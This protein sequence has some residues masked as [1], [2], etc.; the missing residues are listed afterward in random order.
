MD[1]YRRKRDELD[2]K[3]LRTHCGMLLKNQINESE[4]GMENVLR[5][6]VVF[7][8]SQFPIDA[9]L[10]KTVL[11]RY[12]RKRRVPQPEYEM[13][14][15]GKLFQSILTFNEQKYASHYWYVACV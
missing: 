4:V 13:K 7:I 14:S 9:D 6:P 3:G 12:S 10:P 1:F 8:R 15:E 5:L 11:Y 2:S